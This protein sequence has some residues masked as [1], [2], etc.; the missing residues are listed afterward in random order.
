MKEQDIRPQALFAEYIRLATLDADRFFSSSERVSIPCPACSTA[1]I[2]A[3]TKSGFEY[4]E[5]PACRTLF[6]SPRPEASAFGRYCKESES[7]KFWASTFYRETADARREQVWKPKAQLVSDLVKKHAAGTPTIYDIGGGYGI[8]AQEIQRL[9]FR[10]IVI[11]P[12]PHLATICQQSG[13]ETIEAFMEELDTSYFTESPKAFVS[14]ELFEH[15]HDP[16]DF[17]SRTL[18][19]LA[20]GEIFTFTTLSGIGV[21]IQALWQDSKAATPPYH[22][23]FLNPYSIRLLLKRV[24]FGVLEITTPGRLDISILEN[25]RALIRDRFWST[26]IQLATE[27]EKREWQDWIARSGWSSHMMVTCRKPGPG[28]P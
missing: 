19:L 10:A 14:F 5:C 2:P 25:N 27:D 26:F 11:E 3:F 4:A 23:N 15:L 22:L 6:V 18:D 17:L 16:G 9:G 24:G 7:S 1:G 12:A 28:A 21:D 20:P 8:F 13:L